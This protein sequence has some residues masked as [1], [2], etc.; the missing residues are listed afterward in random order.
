MSVTEAARRLGV[1]R[2]ALSNLLN[3]RAALSQ[4]MALRLE[5]TFGADRTRLL[6]LQAARDQDRRN[7]EDRAVAV[8]TYA[9]SFLTIKARQI[10]EWGTGNIQARD[11]LPV[12][13]RRLVHATG[14]ELRRVDFP[15]FDNAQRHGWDGRVEANAATVWVPEGRSFWECGTDHR[16]RAKAERDYRARLGVLARDERAKSTFVFVTPRHWPGKDEW[17]RS[18][19]AAR[20]WKAVRAL[21]ASDLEQW[22]ENTI[23]PRIWLAGELRIPT[24]GFEPLDRFWD[25]WAY[26]SDPPMTDEIFAPSVAAHRER[27]KT[28][29]TKRPGD[30]PLTVAADSRGEAVAFLACLFRHGDTPPPDRDHPVVFESAQT[31]RTLSGSPSPF[32]PIVYGEDAERE[33]AS[34]YRQRR[35]IVVRPRNAVDRRPDI[36]V[37]LLGH[38]PFRKALAHMGFTE[39]ARIDR[40]ASASGRSPTVLRRRL[41]PIPA[42]SEPSWAATESVARRLLPMVLVGAWHA[43]SR[44]DREVLAAIGRCDYDDVEKHVVGLLQ[45]DDSPVWCV[46]RY[47]G[48]VSKIDA[49]SAIR[50]WMTR[51]D[52]V[53]FVD[54]AEYVL[55]ESDPSLALPDDQRWA[56]GLYGRV[57]EHS[58]ALRIGVC[59][60]LAMLSVH[61]N[62]WFRARLGIDVADYIAALVTRL[63]TPFTSDRLKSHDRDLPGYAEAAPEA[64]LALLEADIAQPNPCLQE[65][66]KSAGPSMLQQPWRT[67]VLWALERLAWNPRTFVRVVAILAELS[68]TRVNDNWL[69]S[70]LNSLSAILRWWMPQTAAPL[71]DRLRAIE[72]LCRRFP[73]IGWQLCVQQFETGQQ[74]ASPN[75]RPRWRNDAAGAGEPLLSGE[76]SQFV[77]K[78]L[79]LAIQWPTHNGTTLG[80]LL[81]RLGAMSNED[82]SSVWRRIAEWAQSDADEEAK[83]ALREKVRIMF[84]TRG[85]FHRALGA[86]QR[87][88]ARTICEKLTPRD[89]VRRHSWLFAHEWVPGP[90]DERDGEDVDFEEQE[91]RLDEL[92]KAAMTGIWSARGLDG[93]LGLLASGDAWTIGRYTAYCAGETSAAL[94]V[95]R[96]CLSVDAVSC[97]K[98]DGFMGGFLWFVNEDVRSVFLSNIGKVGNVEQIVR[99]FTSAPFR[100]QTWRLLDGQPEHIRE[101]YWQVVTPKVARFAE[102]EATELVDNLL[103]V[104]RPGVAYSAVQHD[105]DQVETSR[106]KRVLWAVAETGM[107]FGHDGEICRLSMA[108]SSL[109]GRP[110]V[111]VAEMARLEFAFIQELSRIKKAIPNLER[112]ISESPVVFVEA[113]ALLAKRDDNGQDPPQWRVD[114]PERRNVLSA[115]AYRLLKNVRRMPGVDPEGR[116]DAGVLSEWVTEVRR[117]CREHGRAG[118]GDSRVGELLSTAPADEDGSWPCRPVCEV[119]ESVAS[120]DVAEGFQIGVYNARGACWRGVDEGGVQERELA[121][122]YRAWAAQ[123]VIDY[124]YVATILEGIARMYDRDGERVDCDVL[125][126]RRLGW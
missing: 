119:L 112:R 20:D 67:G 77:R 91:K 100:D 64:F 85:G 104:G 42:I 125:A 16:P 108:L 78:A 88:R 33:L 66:L 50:R 74:I 2:P 31:L 59:D 109:G 47:R 54:F 28:W 121:V 114:D 11:R 115:A 45:R 92:R 68:Q 61:G 17:A 79:D 53:D 1:G 10:E 105:W 81:D 62:D 60:S 89:P 111:T 107:E 120:Q 5:A 9:P 63:L 83:A 25:R 4:N 32:I 56:A 93:P 15:G 103:K 86:D 51:K 13:L 44:A 52:I 3:G 73:E 39:R 113:L 122:R 41:S 48:V 7:V 49:L 14:R 98:I 34:H 18:K 43:A 87:D 36:A 65:L 23:A 124:P 96:S 69:N 26:A 29:L 12:L 24:E 35:C 106:L 90:V 22:L 27:F 101:Q 123:R 40:L 99:V 55:S 82:R 8:R 76:R 70:P 118:I 102:S 19:E 37:E 75:D 71:N 21:D 57:R 117:L 80:H 46:D 116:V 30:G 58:D 97:E 95:L 126:R 94:R 72:T 84:L 110:Q 6:E 38:E